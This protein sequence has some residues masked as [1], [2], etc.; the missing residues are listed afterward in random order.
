[1]E[2][3]GRRRRDGADA[4]LERRAVGDELGDVLA[5]PALDVADRAGSACSYGGLVDLDAE[6]DVVDVDEA[7]AERP[8]HRP[9]ELG[10]DRLRGA[11]RRVHRLD[12]DVPSEQKPWASGG[13]TL[14]RTTSSGIAPRVEEARDIGQEDRDV[15]GAALVHRGAGVRPD[16]QRAMAEVAGHLGR[17]VRPRPLDVEVDDP[18]VVQLRGARD[19]R[20]EQDRRRRRR[21]V[22]VDLVAGAHGGDGLR[23]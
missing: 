7:V 8:R 2:G 15:V 20:V 9:V 5:D 4:Q 11:D 14:T 10:D 23:R 12:A 13:V 22:H 1:M 18:D 21:A 17:Q 16:E 6:V 3:H 19:E